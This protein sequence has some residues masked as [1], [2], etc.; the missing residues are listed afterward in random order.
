M[1]RCYAEDNSITAAHCRQSTKVS[2]GPRILPT[3]SRDSSVGIATRLRAG[4]SDDLGSSPYG[5]WV[6]FS[7]TL[8]PDRLWG[9]RSLLYNEYR[10]LFPW[11][12]KRPGHEANHSPLSSAEVK[13]CVALH[14]H[15]PVRLHSV[16]LS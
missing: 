13:E 12:S 1:R 15:S 16:V 7:S 14:L 10:G 9:P 8:C 5:G 2:N 11:G 6:Y 4:R 3:Q